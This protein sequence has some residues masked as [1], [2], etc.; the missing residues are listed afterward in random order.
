[1]KIEHRQTNSL[2]P[3]QGNP[4]TIPDKAVEAVARSIRE[5]GFRQPIL[6]DG[7]DVII[8]GHT[9]LQAAKR[10][11]L[12][13]V[14]CIVAADLTDEQVRALRLADNR[15]AGFTGWDPAKLDAELAALQA[16]AAD[17]CETAGF[18][19]EIEALAESIREEKPFDDAGAQAERKERTAQAL[20]ATVEKVRE[21]VAKAGTE[22]RAVIIHLG[23]GT[24]AIILAD[25]AFADFIA[26]AQ[27]AVDAGEASP[28]AKYLAEVR[29]L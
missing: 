3:Y 9:R 22:L 5:F 17:L 6:I 16:V 24:K 7:Q 1:M 2:K 21:A 12:E 10:L 11:G 19:L 23:G 27:R 13:T 28:L 20:A 29:P 25:P 15:V 26:E 4:R 18:P 8:A 14:P